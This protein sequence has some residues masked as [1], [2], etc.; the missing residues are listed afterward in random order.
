MLTIIAAEGQND[1]S[2]EFDHNHMEE[3]CGTN[4]KSRVKA[5]R[6]ILMREITMINRDTRLGLISAADRR[7]TVMVSGTV[8]NKLHLVAEHD[9]KM[10]ELLE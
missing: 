7:T 6:H 4:S 10:K 1:K 2:H 5:L 8:Y 3:L 9:E